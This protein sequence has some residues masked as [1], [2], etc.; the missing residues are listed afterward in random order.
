MMEELLETVLG[1]L[2]DLLGAAA[3]AI[4]IIGDA[5]NYVLDLLGIQCNG[6][7]KSCS[8]TTKV[9]T[10]CETDKRDDFLDELLKNI[11]DDLFPV[12]GED[13]SR[14]TCDDAYTGNTIKDTN[15]VFVGGTNSSS[16]KS[17]SYDI[18]DIRVEEGSV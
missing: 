5:I 3:S 14:Y 12:T 15:V 2:Q 4:N 17:I 7:G 1:P 13:W 16:P 11:T 18:S 9:C 6:P 10:N 8:K